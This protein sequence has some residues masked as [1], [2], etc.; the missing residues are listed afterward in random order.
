MSSS[1]SDDGISRP[2]H[3]RKS[4]RYKSGRGRTT[5]DLV[6]RRVPWPHHG[7][8]KGQAPK[9]AMFDTLSIPE[10]VSGYLGHATK[11]NLPSATQA[12]MLSHL[13]ELMHDASAYPWEGVRNYHGILL[14][15]MEQNELTWADPHL[16]QELRLPCSYCIPRTGPKRRSL[17]LFSISVWNML[18]Q[19]RSR[20]WPRLP[21]VS[22]LCLVLSSM[23]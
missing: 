15:M 6:L 11:P 18:T 2:K 9:P 19:W 5:N 20:I 8:Y 4:H 13:R 17:S 14:G 12:A 10:F 23:T 3:K 22:H 21:G 16:I 1:E 7:V